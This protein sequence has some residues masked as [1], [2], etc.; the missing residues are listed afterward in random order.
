MKTLNKFLRFVFSMDLLTSR[1]SMDISMYLKLLAKD[2]KIMIQALVFVFQSI[3]WITTHEC[4]VT[5]KTPMARN[6]TYRLF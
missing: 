1:M 5:R 2:K 4:P 6:F 3:Y